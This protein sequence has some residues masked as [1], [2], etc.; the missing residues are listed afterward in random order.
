MPDNMYWVGL[1]GSSKEVKC[2]QHRSLNFIELQRRFDLKSISVGIF[3]LKP[4]GE[5]KR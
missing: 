4:V 3:C 2:I 5:D 1:F